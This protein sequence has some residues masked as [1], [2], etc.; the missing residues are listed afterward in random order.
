MSTKVRGVLNSSVD[1]QTKAQ[2]LRVA[3][4]NEIIPPTVRGNF[5]R[6]CKLEWLYKP[7]RKR[8]CYKPKTKNIVALQAEDKTV[9]LQAEEKK[10]RL[11][12]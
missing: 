11:V 1:L 3:V 12:T 4:Q 2:H 10:E 6:E 5:K 8:W 7:K 9:A